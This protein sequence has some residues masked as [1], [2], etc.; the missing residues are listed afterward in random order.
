MVIEVTGRITSL[1]AS[2]HE[3]RGIVPMS[4]PIFLSHMQARV[5]G[6]TAER[7]RL[8]VAVSESTGRKGGFLTSKQ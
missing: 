6:L 2:L 3:N 8:L 1:T 4:R 5:T 7:D